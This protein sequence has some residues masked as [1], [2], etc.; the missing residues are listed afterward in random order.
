[1]KRLFFV[2]SLLLSLALSLLT[3]LWFQ[4]PATVYEFRDR[5]NKL[6]L[7]QNPEDDMP[8]DAMPAPASPYFGLWIPKIGI[9]APILDVD[10]SNEKEYLPNILRGVGYY[11]H[12][13]LPEV[14]VDGSFP[15]EGGNIFLFGHSQIPGGSLENYQGVFNDLH[16]LVAG[17]RIVVYYQG[18]AFEYEIFEAKVVSK[19]AMEY[20][21][22]TESETLTLM[23][24]WPLGL[25]VKRYIVRAKPVALN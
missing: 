7:V 21:A 13:E 19:H 2:L 20:L 3:L 11:Q 12:K 6:V 17:D 22:R 4:R 5:I 8:I 24:C 25:D 14:T 9:N 18:Q 16:K 10:G 1:M 15:G 23:T